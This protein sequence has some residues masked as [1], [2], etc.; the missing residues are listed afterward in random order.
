MLRKCGLSILVDTNLKTVDFL[1]VTFNLDKNI[2]KAYRK[3]NNSP[4]KKSN[5]PQNLLKQLPK[6][7]AKHISETSSTNKI[8]N[9]SIRIYSKALKERGFT[10]ELKY[11]PNEVQQLKNYK[12]RKRNRK[13]IWLTPPYS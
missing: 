2:Y 3:P 4:N 6:S 11:L 8:F 10:D 1:N 7:I 9:K 13:I 5:H 12:G